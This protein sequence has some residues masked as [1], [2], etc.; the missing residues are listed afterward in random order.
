M[1]S[2]L[3]FMLSS[4]TAFRFCKFCGKA[5]AMIK[6]ILLLGL[7]GEEGMPIYIL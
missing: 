3:R 4:P 1:A 2:V 6:E 5:G 7:Y